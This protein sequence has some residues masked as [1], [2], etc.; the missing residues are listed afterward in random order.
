VNL[1]SGLNNE[2][3]RNRWLKEKLSKLPKK[4]KILDAGAGELANKKYCAHLEYVSQDL[5][6]YEGSGNSSGLQTGSWN[7]DQIDIISDIVNIPEPNESYDVILCSEVFE[8]LPDPVK[9]LHEFKRLLKKDGLLIITA[10]FCSLTHFAPYHF[11][12]GFNRY[13]YEHHF[14]DLG[15]EVVEITA[16]GNYFEYFAQEARRLVSVV[17]SYTNKKTSFFL[18]ILLKILIKFLSKYSKI[19]KG[20]QELL[21]YGYHVVAKKI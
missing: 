14:K 16:N 6:E 19:D 9:A 3:T 7:T 11:S 1:D 15:F 13:Y 8:H 18:R 17:E 21:C 20:S 4:L 5:C 10:P 2:P 12:S